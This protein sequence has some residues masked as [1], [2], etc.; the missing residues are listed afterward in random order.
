MVTP[1]VGRIPPSSDA[2]APSYTLRRNTANIIKERFEH[3]LRDVF[4]L[5]VTKTLRR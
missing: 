5:H 3:Q 1:V 2:T 4:Q